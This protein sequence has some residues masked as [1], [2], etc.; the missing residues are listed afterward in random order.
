MDIWEIVS[1]KIGQSG[2]WKFVDFLWNIPLHRLGG[3]LVEM[4]IYVVQGVVTCFIVTI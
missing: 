2:I 1:T 4:V 3:D